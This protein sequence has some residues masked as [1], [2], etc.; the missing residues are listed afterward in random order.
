MTDEFKQDEFL[1]DDPL[2]SEGEATEPD[3]EETGEDEADTS[4]DE[5]A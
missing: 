3:E 2:E 1:L 5:E 4:T